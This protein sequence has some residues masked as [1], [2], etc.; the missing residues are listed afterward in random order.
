[1]FIIAFVLAPGAEQAFR[2]SI[3]LSNDGWMIFFQRPVAV[4]FFLIAAIAVLAGAFKQ[5][6]ARRSNQLT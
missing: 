1:A 6:R 3:I 2:Q 4:A 5:L